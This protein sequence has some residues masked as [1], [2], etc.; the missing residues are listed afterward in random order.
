MVFSQDQRVFIVEHYFSTQSYAE[1]HNVFRN[2]FPDYVVPNKS[3]VQ[4][5]VKRFPETGSTGKKCHSG[6]RCV[7][8]NDS[9]EDIRAHLRQSPRKSLRKLSQQ[10]GMT[11][12]SI[13]RAAKR[14]KLH[15]YQVQVYHEL[16]TNC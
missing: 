3:T 15:P 6:H 11:Y 5:L 13:Q 14:L 1:C 4:C 16:K 2:S 12:G 10:T 7:L 8:S 9:L